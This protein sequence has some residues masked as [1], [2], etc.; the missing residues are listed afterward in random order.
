MVVVID[1]KV[2]IKVSSDLPMLA[3]DGEVT[4][5][6]TQPLQLMIFIII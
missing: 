5:A 4:W 2:Y 3:Y 6:I 1:S